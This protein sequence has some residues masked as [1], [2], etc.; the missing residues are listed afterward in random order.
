MRLIRKHW[1]VSGLFSA[2]ALM[3][4]AEAAPSQNH[5]M[6]LA[7]VL[8]I[9]LEKNPDLRASSERI[10][11]A[12][13]R[14]MEATAQ[15]Y[16]RLS[17]R[18]GYD[19]TSNPSLAFSYILSQR[20]LSAQTLSNV[21]SLNQPGYV[22]NFRPELLASYNLF[23]GGQDY[24]R[25]K[26]A[27]LGV[28]A[29]SL[30]HTALQNRLIAAITTAFHALSAAPEQHTVAQKA[31]DT[32]TTELK[33]AEAGREAGSQLKSD[34]LTLKVRESEARERELQTRNAIMLSRSSLKVLVGMNAEEALEV[35]EIREQK[36]EHAPP[37]HT[38]PSLIAQALVQRPEMQAASRQYEAREKELMAEKGA[39]L[40]RVNAYTAYG[41]NSSSPDF[42]FN[43]QNVTMGI[44]AEVD[45][46]S[47]GAT[48]AR[49]SAAERR[50]SEADAI[51]EK[52][53]LEIENEVQEAWT[54]F[55]EAEQRLEV[56]RDASEAA[57]EALR[58]VQL[59]YRNNTVNVTRYLEAEADWAAAQTRTIVAR[60]DTHIGRASLD[61]ALG[62]SRGM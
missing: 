41:L 54:S 8:D 30:E 10:A 11:E 61:K 57:E 59:Q 4:Q 51:R 34:V 9:A 14:V 5:A 62:L 1:L 18:V 25:K 12:E 44:N 29:A 56:S 21:N 19:Y 43:Q 24:F 28:E 36:E 40:P 55:R 58:I 7:Q 20:R 52:T 49:I 32:V 13:A 23:Q 26:A 48:Q 17:G 47:G 42:N 53:R 16:P 46:F 3:A 35:Q 45:I 15:F 27:E 22:G 37:E 31:L 6:T 60:F 33:H 50:L 38:L 39:H 2:C